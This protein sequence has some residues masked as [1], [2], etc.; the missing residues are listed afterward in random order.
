MRDDPW[1]TIIAI[2]D[3]EPITLPLSI[4]EE[5]RKIVSMLL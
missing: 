5:N 2:K 4:K 3:A 1:Q